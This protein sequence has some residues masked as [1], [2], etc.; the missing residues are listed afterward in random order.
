MSIGYLFIL[1]C[2]ATV[3]LYTVEFA[4][5]L[6]TVTYKKGL[7]TL[8]LTDDGRQVIHMPSP[9]VT[10]SPPLPS[11]PLLLSFLQ[12]LE[13]FHRNL[14]TSIGQYQE[15][16]QS[17]QLRLQC[18]VAG[19]LISLSSLPHKLNPI[20]RPLMD[21]IKTINN[22]LLQLL[23]SQWLSRLLDLSHDRSPSPN[24]KII[25]NLSGYLCCDA[26]HTPP[27]KPVET[28]G[29]SQEESGHT[30]HKKGGGGHVSW[31]AFDGIISLQKNNRVNM[32]LFGIYYYYYYYYY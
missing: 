31:T 12:E 16:H 13:S 1:F 24:A 11:S 8:T 10:P 23:S 30:S 28:N 9:S 29:R 20:I 2:F 19:S 32:N 6:A 26:N 21:S 15:Y 3:S 22:N 25:K 18:C 27:V 4:V 14:L 17:L 5:Q 7:E